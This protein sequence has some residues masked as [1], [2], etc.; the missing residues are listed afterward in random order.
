MNIV[1]FTS[2]N[3][4]YANKIIKELFKLKEVKII[5]VVES[6]V[7]Y[8]SKSNLSA[9]FMILRKSGFSYLF[10]QILKFSIFKI[11]SSIYQF[12]PSKNFANNLFSYKIICKKNKIPI[13]SAK[14]INSEQFIKKISGK[15]TDL[16]FSIFL[17]QIFKQKLL[18]IPKIGTLNIHPALLPSYRGLSPI[19]WAL[20]NGEKKAGIT[21]H[22]ID[23]K[24][25][26]GEIIAQKEVHIS[27]TDTEF[28]LYFKCVDEGIKIL[29]T[30][31]EN[32]KRGN[33]KSIPTNAIKPSYYSFPTRNEVKEFE[34]RGKKFLTLKELLSF[35]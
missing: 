4:I 19:F 1:I 15:K 25:D 12:F 32:I 8:P 22:W 13:Y 23:D 17:N 30:V 11:G 34:K 24:I 10:S 27:P 21:I 31:F 26:S 2:K 35:K 3:N 28:S 29:K 6:S 7:I 9:L 5:G 20:K 18:S 33:I 14:N 16:F